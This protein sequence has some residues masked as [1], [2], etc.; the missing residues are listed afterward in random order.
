MKEI[1]D[2]L[3]KLVEYILYC[4]EHGY[5]TNRTKEELLKIINPVEYE[6]DYNERKHK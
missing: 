1:Q 6:G 5:M 3:V 4:A 2:M